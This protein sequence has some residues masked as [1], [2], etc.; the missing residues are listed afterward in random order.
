MLRIDCPH[1]GTRDEVEF[2]Y[3]GD[4]GVR[5]PAADADVGAF[6]AYVYE[7]ANPRGWHLE[8]WYHAAG[9]RQ[10]L[11][12]WRPTVTHDIHAVGTATG[13]LPAPPGAAST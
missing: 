7:R 10:Y 6:A 4:A 2:R 12:V 9:C 3:R 1:C 13:S 8:W 5:R 11:Q